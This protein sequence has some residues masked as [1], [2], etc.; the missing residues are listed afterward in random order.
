M[1]I[2][3]T[4]CKNAISRHEGLATPRRIHISHVINT[5][6]QLDQRC[7]SWSEPV[8]GRNPHPIFIL[9]LGQIL[10]S[11]ILRYSVLQNAQRPRRKLSERPER[12]ELYKIGYSNS[13]VHPSANAHFD[14]LRFSDCAARSGQRKV[15]C[16][17]F[18]RFVL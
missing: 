18:S 14:T 11:L 15:H 5:L 7:F 10:Y 13:R 4:W 12:R 9:G 16:V 17:L 3:L 1:L 2:F 6:F 8:F